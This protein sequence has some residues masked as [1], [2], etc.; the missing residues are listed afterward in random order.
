MSDHDERPKD[1]RDDRDRASDDDKT[2]GSKRW[3]EPH[4]PD[5]TRG[6]PPFRPNKPV[7]EDV[8]KI[9]DELRRETSRPL[10]TARPPAA[11][12][13]A[14]SPVTP[15][16][17][18]PT[19][20]PPVDRPTEAYRAPTTPASAA[21]T[22]RPPIDDDRTQAIPAADLPTMAR[23][24]I[25]PAR[26]PVERPPVSPPP[27]ARPAPQP[28]RSAGDILPPART[29]PPPPP[30]ATPRKPVAE[31]RRLRRG[32]LVIRKIDPWAVFR[33]SLVF[34]FCLLLIF[35]MGTAIIFGALKAFGVVGNLEEL[36]REAGADVTFRGGVIFRWLFLV[37]LVGT[38]VWSAITVFMAFL[39]N[40][41]AD[42][43]GGIEL[44]VTERE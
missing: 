30:A 24:P 29:A 43:V 12:P 10:E 38:V 14:R 21:P 36:F 34:Y 3:L 16:P 9:Y 26:P 8:S 28:A 5:P 40:L 13:P 17:A 2:Q 23:P 37:G 35:L 11:T 18:S 25:S 20:R 31:V 4:D 19:P 44:L 27:A 7:R 1:D 39:Y 15:T 22:P 32:R 33:F 42:V 6:L 41:I